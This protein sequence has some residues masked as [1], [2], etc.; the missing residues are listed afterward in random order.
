M[1]TT[2]TTA[3]PTYGFMNYFL[4][5]GRNLLPAAPEKS[6]THIGAGS[7]LIYV[8]PENDLVIVARWIQEKAFAGV[9]EKVLS[10]V[11]GR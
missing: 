4:N 2:P 3:E 7:N 5:T 6:F 11:N 9:V 8:D 1:A 10:A